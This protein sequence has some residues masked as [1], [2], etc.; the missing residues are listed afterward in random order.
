MSR[1]FLIYTF[2]FVV[3]GGCATDPGQVPGEVGR[4]EGAVREG[5]AGRILPRQVLGRPQHQHLR[6]EQRLLRGHHN[7]SDDNT[8]MR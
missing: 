2:F 1:N 8:V 5:A 3:A 4:P 7:V 6:R